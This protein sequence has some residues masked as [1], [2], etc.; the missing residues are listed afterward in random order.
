MQD[1][2]AAI[3]PGQICTF[4]V[5]KSLVLTED[6]IDMLLQLDLS[7]V[8]ELFW[9]D[10]RGSQVKNLIEKMQQLLRKMTSLVSAEFYATDDYFDPTTMFP[11]T[12]C[13]WT[14]LGLEKCLGRN[15]IRDLRIGYDFSLF[16]LL[17]VLQ[18]TLF[19]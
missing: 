3:F 13:Y 7:K 17:L 8:E 11:N 4:L 12:D 19:V 10:I 5:I 14:E 2:P 18:G 15:C 9:Y 1:V 6:L 16:G